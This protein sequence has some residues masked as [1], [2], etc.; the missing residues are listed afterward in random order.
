MTRIAVASLHTFLAA[1]LAGGGTILLAQ[2]VLN[3]TWET[4]FY[5]EISLVTA[6]VLV[7]SILMLLLAATAVVSGFSFA[8]GSRWGGWGLIAVSILLL[9]AAPPPLSWL[10]ALA[11]VAV[12][13]DLWA[14]RPHPPEED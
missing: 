7:T 14:R 8:L 2:A 12:G 3:A 10:L 5:G 13:L 11:A 9:A 6:A 4:G 1:L